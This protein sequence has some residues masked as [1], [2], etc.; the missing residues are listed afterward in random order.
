MGGGGGGRSIAPLVAGDDQCLLH[1]IQC[2]QD[3]IVVLGRLGD[4]LKDE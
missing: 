1:A 3:L 2:R 4:P